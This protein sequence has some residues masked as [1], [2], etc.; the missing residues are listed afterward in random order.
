MPAFR[1]E[2]VIHTSAAACFDLSLLV[3]AHAASMADARE[4]AVA[5]VTSG[6]MA[7]GDTVTW[8]ARHFGLPFRMTSAITAWERPH[9]FVDEQQSGPFA[10]WWHEHTFVSRSPDVTVMTDAVRFRS[11]L[12]PVGAVVDALVLAGYMQRLIRKRNDWLRST[13]NG[14][15]AAGPAGPA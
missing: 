10:F 7:L 13:L 3:D 9:R 11:P 8:R 4:R 6:A 14:A 2:T 1:T 5:G 15:E 12:G